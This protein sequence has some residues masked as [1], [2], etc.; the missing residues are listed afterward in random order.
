M[1]LTIIRHQVRDY[2]AWRKVYDSVGPM[3][4]AGGVIE[5][6]VY[7]AKNDPNDVVVLHRFNSIEE[8]EKFLVSSDLKD[9]MQRAGVVGAP[10]IE[11]VEDARRPARV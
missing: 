5:E 2:E 3:W 8:A 9:A 11:V 1:A 6:S 4:K 10:R 7:Q